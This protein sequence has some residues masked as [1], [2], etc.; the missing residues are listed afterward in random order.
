[1]LDS[2]QKTLFKGTCNQ[3]YNL[4]T[5]STLN[6]QDASWSDTGDLAMKVT[7]LFPEG[8]S[9]SRSFAQEGVAS[10]YL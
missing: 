5:T 2:G 8:K 7:V 1:M 3:I 9:A 4:P 10:T 6:E